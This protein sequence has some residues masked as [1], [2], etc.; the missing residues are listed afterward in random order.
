MK[1]EIKYISKGGVK[2]NDIKRQRRALYAP[3]L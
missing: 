2:Q 1:K 3:H